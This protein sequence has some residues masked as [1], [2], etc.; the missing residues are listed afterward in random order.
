MTQERKQVL[1]MLAQGKITVQDAERLLDKLSAIG[2]SVPESEAGRTA[3][4]GP[5][6][7]G[8]GGASRS[9]RPKYLRVLVDSSKGDKVNIRVPLSLVRAGI[10]LKAVM[11]EHARQQLSEKGIDLSNLGGLE[12][13]ELLQALRELN[14]DV[15]AADGDKVRIFCE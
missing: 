9:G 14:V 10:K 12:G 6:P 15:D 7:S 11:P 2:T 1:D 3:A 8:E 4:V 13:E 5:E